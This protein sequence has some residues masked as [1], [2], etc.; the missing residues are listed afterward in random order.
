MIVCVG[1]AVC[2]LASG[3]EAAS[4]RS[5][6]L[7]GRLVVRER[8]GLS[9]RAL[10]QALRAAGARRLGGV[11]EL[12]TS[13]LEADDT[14]LAAIEATLR[15]SGLFRSV[16]RDYLAHVAEAND[17]YF[18]SQWGLARVGAPASWALSSGAG[19]TVAVLDTGVE[20]THPDLLGHLQPGYDFLNDDDDPA[21]DH[22]HGTRMSGIIAAT[23]NNAIG[24]SGVAPQAQILPVKVLDAQGN[25]PYSVV[26]SGITYAVDHGARVLNLS[27]AG[28]APSSVLQAAIDY[29][30]ANQV[31]LVAAS[32]NSGNDVPAY[33]AAADG[34][35]A[36][37][38]INDADL[39][40]S[41]S[42]YGSWLSFAAPGVDVV[43]TTLG[44]QYA[45]SS[46]TSPAAAFGSGVFA[47]LFGA[48]PTMSRS[49][50]IAR[51]Q[52]GTIDL[53]SA[54]WDP[55]FGH[56]RAD[57]YAALVPGQHGAPKQDV[58]DP[59]IGI[60]SPAKDSL[61]SG[62]IPVDI[63]A[64]DDVAI[65]R[66]D[67]YVDG[68]FAAT[69]STPP[70]GFVLDAA[71]Y[72]SG[73]HK[74]RAYAYD[75]AGNSTKTRNHKLSFTSGVGL[76]VSSAKARSSSLS[77]T[78]KFALPAGTSFDPSRDAVVVSVTSARG[79]V[80]AATVDAGAL[81]ASGSGKMQGT[82]RANVPAVG[83]VRITAKPSGDQAIYAFK[84]KASNL[85][86]MTALDPQM[87]LTVQV[88]DA[89]LSQSLPFRPKGT[90]LIY[91]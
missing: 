35:V 23:Q 58:A 74:L 44:G 59:E 28:S 6:R 86:G 64:S 9:A 75:T 55:Y 11:A 33:P 21:D 5:E 90:T 24:I 72:G 66:V 36:V 20:R 32:G 26:A 60:V 57:A 76:L 41:F 45:G 81:V 18:Q 65:A 31:V 78:A 67:L 15:R 82:V 38:A 62:M 39:R 91:P 63:A 4:P 50:A 88:G 13:V 83:S 10:D 17:L 56:G 85:T 19:V 29:A 80:L 16:E 61:V 34:A 25:G 89:Q 27:L 77:I 3:G 52:A 51:V 12:D 68:R 8:A 69:T 7:A 46:G 53:G 1:V 87:S 73:L 30:T 54:G 71:D 22:G 49:E 70:Y 37:G 43:T 14:D 47:L 79:T 40:A 84:L 42:N 2:G 48:N